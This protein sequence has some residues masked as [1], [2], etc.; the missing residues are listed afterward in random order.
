L[1]WQAGATMVPKNAGP[2]SLLTPA[3]QN[4]SIFPH[5][6]DTSR[7][8]LAKS[9]GARRHEAKL[10]AIFPAREALGCPLSRRRRF[11]RSRGSRQTFPAHFEIRN[12]LAVL[13]CFVGCT[14]DAQDVGWMDGCQH[15]TAVRQ[16]HDAP[17]DFVAVGILERARIDLVNDTMPPAGCHRKT[18]APE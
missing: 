18:L 12:Q 17:A 14:L 9:P 8:S 13:C 11:F 10:T 7:N 6:Y 2:A 16:R 15:A 5:G 4:A 3:A 1:A